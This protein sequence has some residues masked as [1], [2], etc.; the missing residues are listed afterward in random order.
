MDPLSRDILT[1][2]LSQY[3]ME[4][5]FPQLEGRQVDAAIEGACFQLLRQICA[6]VRDESCDDP[7]CFMRIEA[8]VQALSDHGISAGFRHDFG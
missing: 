3:P 7:E 6:I 2:L 5:T 4:I 1:G 8:I